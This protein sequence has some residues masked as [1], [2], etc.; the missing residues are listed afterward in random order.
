MVADASIY[1]LI[2]PYD[3]GPGPLELYGK[4]AQIKNLMGQGQLQDLQTQK[5]SRDLSEEQQVRE[6]FRKYPDGKVPIGELFAASPTH[7][8]TFQK[9]ALDIEKAR[10]DIGKTALESQA[11]QVK[12]IRDIAAQVGSDADMPAAREAVARVVGPDKGAQ[13][14]FFNTPFTPENKLRA[15]TTADEHFKQLEAQRG[16]DVTLAGHAETARHNLATE[17]QGKYSTPIEATGA[18]GRPVMVVQDRKSGELFDA[19]TRAPVTG[20]TPKLNQPTPPTVGQMAMVQSAKSDLDNYEKLLFPSGKFDR[21]MIYRTNV[22][23]AAGMPG[24]TKARQAYSALNNAIAAKLRLET[25]AQANDQEIEEIAKRFRP[26]VGDTE[27]SARDKVG[28]LKQFMETT[29]GMT[30]ATPNAAPAVRSTGPSPSSLS[31]D[32]LLREL[33]K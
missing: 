2:K 13:L 33:S 26:N 4:A 3:A 14:P 7:A 30:R 11:L 5:L 8:L 18:D 24:D 12:Q 10:G 27:A 1:G 6:L 32:E 9:S 29:L 21:S 16:R 31:N 15:I 22:P 25:G 28:R 23:F 19:T 20:I 17:E